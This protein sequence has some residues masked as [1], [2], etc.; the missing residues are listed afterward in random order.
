MCIISCSCLWCENVSCF[1]FFPCSLVI[2]HINYSIIPPRRR[3]SSTRLQSKRIKNSTAASTR[4][5]NVTQSAA[6]TALT[7]ASVEQLRSLS[8]SLLRHHLKA[9]SLS[10]S[11]NKVVM[12]NRLYSY[13]H[14]SGE[15]RSAN[16]SDSVVP[17]QDNRANSDNLVAPP[18]GNGGHSTTTANSSATLDHDNWAP[19]QGNGGQPLTDSNV[20]LTTQLTHQLTN[21]FRQFMPVTGHKVKPPTQR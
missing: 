5:D 7:T 4:S 10:S 6:Q 8:A 19:S 11:G 16:S 15:T 20:D 3:G 17:P 12:A 9:N 21:F 14:T 2:Y 13:F 18:Q 1:V